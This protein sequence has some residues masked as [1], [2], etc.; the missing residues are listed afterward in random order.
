MAQIGADGVSTNRQSIR[1]FL[2]FYLRESATSA[3]EIR[4]REVNGH[5]VA[6]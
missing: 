3:E 6:G 4:N 5:S 2:L 1:V